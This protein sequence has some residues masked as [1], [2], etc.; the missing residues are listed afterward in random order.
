M[1]LHKYTLKQLNEAVQT[2]KSVRS[3]LKKL[4]VIEA[5][6]NYEIFKKAVTVFNIDISHFTGKGWCSGKVLPKR[7]PHVSEYLTKTSTIQSNRLRKYLIEDS[8]FEHKCTSCGI[9]EWQ[10]RLTPIELDHIDGDK[11]NNEL[12]NLRLLCP[13][14]HAQTPTY[15]GK[16]KKLL[17]NRTRTCIG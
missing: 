13:N 3:C 7:R 2:S 5:G 1:K 4:N 16:N 11:T 12:S 17:R 9:T 8:I 10:G 6:G 15:C 14:C